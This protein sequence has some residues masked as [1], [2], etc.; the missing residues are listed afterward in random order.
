[1]HQLKGNIGQKKNRTGKDVKTRQEAMLLP[2]QRKVSPNNEAMFYQ[3]Q[4]FLSV[5][6]RLQRL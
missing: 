3:Q 1:M 4:L 6:G 5:E 2:C